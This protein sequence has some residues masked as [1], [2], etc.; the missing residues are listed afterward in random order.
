M[1]PSANHANP[2]KSPRRIRVTRGGSHR[3]PRTVRIARAYHKDPHSPWHGALRRYRPPAAT[4][5]STRPLFALMTS[6]ERLKITRNVPSAGGERR[7]A[8][9]LGICWA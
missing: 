4:L 8:S 3:L 2:S 1:R 7:R 6:S 9:G 5:S